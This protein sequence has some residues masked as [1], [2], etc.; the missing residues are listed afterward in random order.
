MNTARRWIIRIAVPVLVLELMSYLML[1]GAAKLEPRAVVE[2]YLD[3]VFATYSDGDLQKFLSKSYDPLLGW[4]WGRETSVTSKNKAG[5]EITQHFDPAGYRVDGLPKD[6]P[7]INA[8]GDS[9]TEAH[10]VEDHETWERKLS[11]RL[12][13]P[14]ANYGVG[15]FSTGQAYIR[16]RQHAK[17]G[18]VAPI[19]IL[20]IMEDNLRRNSNLFVPYYGLGANVVFRPSF[21]CPNGTLAERPNPHSDPSLTRADLR[22]LAEDLHEAD[23]HGATMVHLSPPYTLR[24]GQL[25]WNLTQFKMAG[26]S[27]WENP[28]LVRTMGCLADAFVD[29]AKQAKTVPVILFFPS[30]GELGPDHVPPYQALKQQLAAKHPDV[31]IID[32][33]DVL[34]RVDPAQMNVVPFS[35]HLSPFGNDKAAEEVYRVLSEHPSTKALVE[36]R[37]AQAP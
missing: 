4:A 13:R 33:T 36:A 32:V 7:L 17:E 16:F 34:P 2:L 10:E 6:N 8:Y 27:T 11:E 12:D 3:R 18:R 24:V 21:T 23:F 30:V 26:G 28:D 14:V 29:T 19:T 5:K 15:A 20:G 25:L 31:A 9:F 1:R 35:G 22:R 37:G